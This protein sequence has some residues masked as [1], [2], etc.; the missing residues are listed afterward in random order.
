M[1]KATRT[2]LTNQRSENMHEFHAFTRQDTGIVPW[3]IRGASL[4]AA[5]SV[6]RRECARLGYVFL[7]IQSA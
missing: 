7:S 3:T 6:A 2:A 4:V 1:N 5:E